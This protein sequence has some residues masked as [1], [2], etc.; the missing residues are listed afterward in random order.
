VSGVSLRV[1]VPLARPDDRNADRRYILRAGNQLIVLLVFMRAAAR[2]S[3]LRF[4]C[5]VASSECLYHRLILSSSPVHL[6]RAKHRTVMPGITA[7]L[8]AQRSATQDLS[9]F[10]KKRL[11]DVALIGRFDLNKGTTWDAYARTASMPIAPPA[12]GE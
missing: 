12:D 3:I 10:V 8:L 9:D 7:G 11:P 5:V 1:D 6:A 4:D 2:G